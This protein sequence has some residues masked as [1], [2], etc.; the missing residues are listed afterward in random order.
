MVYEV[1]EK[2]GFQGTLSD[3]RA[4]LNNRTRV[5]QPTPKVASR[6]PLL[7]KD[8]SGLAHLSWL[9]ANGPKTIPRYVASLR[10]LTVPQ[11][12]ADDC[13]LLGDDLELG[14]PATRG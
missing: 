7:A 8:C 10:T 2:T 6:E 4:M 12:G 14:G 9:V 5:I 3:A 11:G 13:E 1:L